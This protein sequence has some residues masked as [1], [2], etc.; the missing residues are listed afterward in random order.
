[1]VR[2]IKL[3]RP[4]F[5]VTAFPYG[6]GSS[7]PLMRFHISRSSPM[8][9]F[10]S[11]IDPGRRWLAKHLHRLRRTLE[12]L[13]QRL[14]EGVAVAA[15]RAAEDAVREAVHLLLTDTPALG[16]PDVPRRIFSPAPEWRDPDDEDLR[17]WEE[18]LDQEQEER[19]GAAPEPEPEP[20]RLRRALAEGL[21]AAS[22]WL[23]QDGRFPLL[24]AVAA[25]VL[26]VLTSYVGG[27]LLGAG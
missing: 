9:L 13:C 8:R 25:G 18:N 7:Q 2:N 16:P 24:K 26:I 15:G 27:P 5:P 23:R 19:K 20:A 6:K 11:V 17:R 10:H 14:R 21:Q 1:M 12:A 4:V 22:W 3:H